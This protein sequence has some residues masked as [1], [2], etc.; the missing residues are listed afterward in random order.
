MVCVVMARM[1]G[2][3]QVLEWM[4]F[5]HLLRS[6]SVETADEQIVIV[7]IDENDIKTVGKYPIPDPTLAKLLQTLQS[8]QPRAI[9]LDIF[10]DL[11]QGSSRAE[12]AQVLSSSTNLI[13]I[14]SSLSSNPALTVKPPPELPPVRIGLANV[15]ID[16]DGKL[17]RSLLASKVEGKTLL[18]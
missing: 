13:G 9:G 10:R 12:L 14:E 8:Y 1:M 3:L 16:S 4:T 5:D 18:D 17:R 15:V 7:G 11:N 2:S 6:R